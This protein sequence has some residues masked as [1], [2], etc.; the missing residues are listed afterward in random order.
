MGIYLSS[1][2]DWAV[3]IKEVCLKA[4]RKLSVLRSVKLLSRQTL[5]ILYKIT[6]R[7]VIDY[8][9][10]LY[11]KTLKQTEIARLENVQYRAAKIV[12][13]AYHYTSK[14]KLNSELGWETIQ[15]RADILG[16]NIFNK[17]HK[18]ETRPLVRQCMS[19]FDTDKKHELRSKG[20]Y[21]SFKNVGE[22]FKKSF[23]PH[24]T[25]LWN[26]LPKNVREYSELTD[27]KNYTKDLKPTRY[28]H[29]AK[30][31]KYSNSLLT[32]IRVGRSELNQHTNVYVISRRSPLYITLLTVSYTHKN[33]RLYFP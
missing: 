11:F 1:T 18:L 12:T 22:K 29:F 13:G 33:V 31:N 20:G 14:D 6:V 27:F 30:G 23:F 21:I 15:K 4:N 7:S 24:F 26:N 2:L 32:K 10:P 19:K 17:I 25:E 8:A 28:K 9:L 3:Q 16:L 5:D